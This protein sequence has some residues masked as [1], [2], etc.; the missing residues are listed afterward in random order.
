MSAGHR[1]HWTSVGAAFRRL[2]GALLLAGLALTGTIGCSSPPQP[3]PEIRIGLIANIDN[4]S[5]RA[6]AAA[7]KLAIDQVNRAGGL[8][9]AGVKRKLVLVTGND[10][11]QPEEAVKA[12]KRLINQ[13]NVVALI[14]PNWSKNA[15]PV[16][17]IAERSRVPMISPGSTNPLTTAGKKYVR[18][19]TFVDSFQGRVVARFAL[20]DLGARRAAVLYDVASAY[21][22]GIAEIFKDAFLTGGGHVVAF[23]SYT[24]GAT[25]FTAQ[26]TRIKAARPDVLFLPNYAQDVLRQAEQARTMGIEAVI[27]GS[28]GWNYDLAS[29]PYLAGAFFSDHWHPDVANDKAR[30]FIKAYRAAYGDAEPLVS[31]A[32]LTYD[33]M[34]LLLAAI[35]EQDK[36]DAESINRGLKRLGP[37]MGVTGVIEYKKNGD[38]I[39]GAVICQIKDKRVAFFKRIGP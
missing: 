12:A 35:A 36:A 5:G 2:G 3:P 38:P 37:F 9:V 32:A 13:E 33:A 23:E 14:G 7:A 6:A 4:E 30:E 22:R 34:G 24:T 17:A 26:L 29:S 25:D 19:V 27:L 18:R 31:M 10:R 28:D 39:K 1:D 15:I 20:E 8:S 16:A 21:N 11:G